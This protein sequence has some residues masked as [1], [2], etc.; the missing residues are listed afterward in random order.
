MAQRTAHPAENSSYTSRMSSIPLPA[1]DTPRPRGLA[2]G[3]HGKSLRSSVAGPYLPRLTGRNP[4]FERAVGGAVS[5]LRS[6]NPELMARVRVQVGTM[7]SDNTLRDGIDRFR[8]E[9]STIT[10]W[11]LPIQRLESLHCDDP[12]HLHDLV[13]SVLIDA[14]AEMTGRDPWSIAPDRFGH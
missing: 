8:V 4:E 12:V 1:H 9:G 6:A 7:P 14:L 10:L 3:R 13:E 11:R 5:Y 2:R